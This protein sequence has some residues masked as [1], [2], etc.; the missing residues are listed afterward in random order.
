MLSRRF[1]AFLALHFL[2][3]AAIVAGCTIK[4]SPTDRDVDESSTGPGTGGSDGTGGS[5]GTGGTGGSGGTGGPDDFCVGEVGKGDT[6][7]V[8]DDMAI[9]P[10]NGAS[11]QCGD[12]KN[13]DPYG[14]RLCKR[15]FTTFAGGHAE[16]LFSCLDTIGVQDACDFELANDCLTLMFDDA[17]EAKAFNAQSE[18]T[19]MSSACA[20]G[21]DPGFDVNACIL[22][23]NPFNSATLTSLKVCIND[24]APATLSCQ[25]AYDFCMDKIMTF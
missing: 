20:S 4:N 14:Y 8:C 21:S 3:P 7:A 5:G 9:S 22:D 18:C 2:L 10:E 12:G 1:S 25:E 19:T 17:C 24:E 6:V 15:G 23:V 13:E 16:N 11:Q